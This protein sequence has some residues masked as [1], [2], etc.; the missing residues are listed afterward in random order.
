MPFASSPMPEHGEAWLSVGD[1]Q[2]EADADA[3][4]KDRE[5]TKR[6]LYVALTR[7]RDRLYLASEV[8][9]AR[10]RAFGGSL[11]DILPPGV[12]ARFEAASMSPAPE[13][14]EWAA[15]SGHVH[16]FRV[17]STQSREDA[18]DSSNEISSLRLGASASRPDER[19]PDNFAPLI[20]PFELPRVA[21]TTSARARSGEAAPQSDRHEQPQP[22]GHPRASVVRALRHIACRRRSCSGRSPTSSRG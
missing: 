13:T 17:C 5:E 14:T 21:V 20:D 6:L 10:W 1:F 9:D 12:K 22:H 2:S 8:K 15:A 3:K 4:A 7:A 19:S 18:R 11:G 16:T